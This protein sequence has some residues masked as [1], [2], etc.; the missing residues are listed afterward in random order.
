MALLFVRQQVHLRSHCDHMSTDLNIPVCGFA[1][2]LVFSFLRLRTPTGTL[3]EKMRQMDWMY[4][5]H[6]YICMC[7]DT[8]THYLVEICW[9]LL[10]PAHAWLL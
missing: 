2:I 5:L 3:K 7:N 8:E 6:L 10:V 1:G 4:V 9:S